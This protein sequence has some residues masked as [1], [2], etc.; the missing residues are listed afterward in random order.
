MP[1]GET[2]PRIADKVRRDNNF[3]GRGGK[4]PND[5]RLARPPSRNSQ[6]ISNLVGRDI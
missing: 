4:F 2:G 6:K 3:S 5:R 1:K